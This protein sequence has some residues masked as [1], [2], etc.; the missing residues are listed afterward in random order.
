M[1]LRH[2]FERPLREHPETLWREWWV[3]VR[4][5]EKV[6]VTRSFSCVLRSRSEQK[7][8]EAVSE[9]R[10]AEGRVGHEI[11]DVTVTGFLDDS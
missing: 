3:V 5:G 7:L 6:S 2:Y 11:S 10:G 8:R 4:R 9:R 1:S